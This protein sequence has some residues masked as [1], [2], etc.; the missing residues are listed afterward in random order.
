MIFNVSSLFLSS[1]SVPLNLS[2]QNLSFH[3]SLFLYVCLSM[4]ICLSL[5]LSNMYLQVA[6]ILS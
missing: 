5:S 6:F 1:L 2:L 4:S 3:Y